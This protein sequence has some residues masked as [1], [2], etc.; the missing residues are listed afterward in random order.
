MRI[1][2]L[3]IAGLIGLFGVWWMTSAPPA[4]IVIGEA[5][6]FSA[7]PASLAAVTSSG[8][9]IAQN[10]PAQRWLCRPMTMLC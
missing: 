9:Y 3:I 2:I 1:A 10:A 4:A 5:A 6:A 8:D 7:P